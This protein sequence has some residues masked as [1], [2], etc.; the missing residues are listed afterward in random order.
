MHE[1]LEPVAR[2]PPPDQ[3]GPRGASRPASTSGGSSRGAGRG[4]ARPG[5][6]PPAPERR[7]GMTSAWDRVCRV[8]VM[9]VPLLGIASADGR[10]AVVT[11]AGWWAGAAA[12]RGGSGRGRRRPRRG[13]R[14]RSRARPGRPRPGPRTAGSRASASAHR[15]SPGR[16]TTSPG[17]ATGA[18]A[19]DRCCP[20]DGRA[21]PGRTVGGGAVGQREADGRVGVA[22]G[23]PRGGGDAGDARRPRRRQHQATGQPARRR[24]TRPPHQPDRRRSGDHP[25]DRRR[26]RARGAHGHQ[27][28]LEAAL[29]GRGAPAGCGPPPRRVAAGGAGAQPDGQARA[30][31]VPPRHPEP[32]VCVRLHQST[33]LC[34]GCQRV[35]HRLGSRSCAGTTSC[36]RCS[37]TSRGRRRRCTTPNGRPSSPTAA[38]PSTAPSRSPSRLMASAGSV[39]ALEMAGVGRVEGAL[40]RGRRGGACSRASRTGSSARARPRRSRGL[41]R[42][43]PEVAWSPL[44]R[45][46]LGSALRRLADRGRGACCTWP[47]AP[48]TRRR[49]PGRCG[50]RRGRAAGR[51]RGCWCLRRHRGGPVALSADGNAHASATAG[52]VR[53]RSPRRVPSRRTC[54]GEADGPGS[55]G[56]S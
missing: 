39:V 33:K 49:A 5:R 9:A 19:G 14:H 40:R 37:T 23:R 31:M 53:D 26:Q 8:V 22:A 29:P 30:A 13:W 45:L 21:R 18:A 54:A 20:G 3:V 15:E 27:Q 28:V 43:V 24:G 25:T 38:A 46:G 51:R 44:H 56:S 35:F 52:T 4:P 1:G 55:S 41:G 12:A 2:S 47:T 10:S 48:S 16:T 7:S 6:W 17:A 11:L 36:S 34:D 50:L 32:F 42:S